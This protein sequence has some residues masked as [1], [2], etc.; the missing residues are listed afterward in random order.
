MALTKGELVKVN[1]KGN[2]HR[3]TVTRTDG[4]SGKCKDDFLEIVGTLDANSE[5]D[6]DF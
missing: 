1:K 4:V 5:F 3:W 6:Q 2:K